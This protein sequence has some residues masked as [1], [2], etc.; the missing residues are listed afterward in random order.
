MNNIASS[1]KIELA[2]KRDINFIWLSQDFK[3]PNYNSLNFSK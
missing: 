1:R 2:Y 3:I